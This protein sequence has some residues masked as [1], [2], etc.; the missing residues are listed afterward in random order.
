[1][2]PQV[3][4]VMPVRDGQR[5][6]SLAIE[7]VL[8]QTVRDLELLVV[9][10]GSGDATPEIVRG[11]SARDDRVRLV[12]QPPSGISAALNAGLEAA[13]SP[14]V[15]RLDADDVALPERLER[16]LAAARS[17]PDVIVWASW[18]QTIDVEGRPIGRVST[19]PVTDAE[20]ARDHAAGFVEILHPTVM[21]RRD[22]ALDVGGY[23]SRFDG[24]ED[25]ELWDRMGVLGPML[26]L[27]ETLVRFR[28][29]GGSF[30]TERFAE[31]VRIHRFVAARRRAAARGEE[32]DIAAFLAAEDA[33]SPL[34]QLAR[35]L[36]VRARLRYRRAGVAYA[37]G[38]RAAT[39]GHLLAALSVSPRYTATRLWRQVVSARF[40]REA[41][42]GG[43]R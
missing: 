41:D 43:T 4:V 18:A 23:D 15:A 28:V 35:D 5:F 39:A 33:A 27:P 9:D 21:L 20:F 25:V 31:G 26:T 38:R 42:V 10:D 2:T 11:F 22:V 3:S 19:G 8:S 36:G 24:A 29:H 32:L 13:R 40:A 34:H 7:S 16:Q 6:L 37:E 12:Q 30:S 1:M 14:W 17:R